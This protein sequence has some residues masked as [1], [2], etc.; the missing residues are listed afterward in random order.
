MLSADCPSFILPALPFVF[1]TQ[2]DH[3]VS[4]SVL[5]NLTPPTSVQLTKYYYKAHVQEL[6][7]KFDTVKELGSATAEEWI[8][9]LDQEGKERANDAVRWEQ[10]VAR[11]GFK[12]VNLRPQDKRITTPIV[13]ATQAD[14]STLKLDIQ[15]SNPALQYSHHEN[16]LNNF[17]Q[18]PYPVVS[19]EPT[20]RFQSG[21][22]TS[23][24]I[25]FVS[26]SA[27]G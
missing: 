3:M 22:C 11:G 2:A 1:L 8:K 9:G 13:S 24:P 17:Q 15:S 20:S 16:N 12:K 21:P 19:T 26:I 23:Y 5:R 6:K 4:I 27:T 7:R 10:W 14:A 25:I 18:T